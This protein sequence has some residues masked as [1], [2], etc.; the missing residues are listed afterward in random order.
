MDDIATAAGVH[1]T[2]VYE[3]FPNRD[4]VL[5]AVFAREAAEVIDAAA[6]QLRRQPTFGEG[7]VWAIAEGVELMRDSARPGALLG[8]TDAGNTI[9]AALASEV[10]AGQVGEA[11]AEPMR[12]AIARGE[13]RGDVPLDALLAWVVRIALSV[14]TEPPGSAP[15]DVRATLRRF[16]LP[17]VLPGPSAQRS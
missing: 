11:L 3:Y 13:V 17:A 5:V 16:L 12:A 1:R 2:T 7:L 15:D 8:P 9:H 10:F 6:V 4:A 14:T